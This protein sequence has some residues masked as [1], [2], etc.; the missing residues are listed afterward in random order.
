MDTKFLLT[1]P[2]EMHDC[3][4][5]QLDVILISGDSYIDSPYIGVAVI[6]RV[7]EKAGFR[8]GI[9]TQPDF[10]S[11]KDI[12]RLGEPRLFWGVTGGSVDSMVANTTASKKKRRTDDYTPG[13]VNDRRPDRA[14]MVYTNLIRRFYKNTRPIVLGGIE[15]SLRRVAHY[16]FWD[17]AIRRSILFD[18]KADYLLYGMAEGSVLALAQAL[19]LGEKATDLRGLCY[20]TREPPPGYLEL[21]SFEEVSADKSAFARMFHTFYQNN[22]PI[23]AHGLTQKHGDR[24]LVQ[25]PPAANPSQTE[26]DDIYALP[27]QRA[28]H[29]YYEK[30]GKVK[31][32]ETIRFSINMQRG[33]YGECNFCSIAVHEGRTVRWRSAASI[34]AEAEALTQLSGFKGYILDVGGPT[35]NMYGFECPLKL[36]EG[37]CV[38]KR[39]IYP[40]VCKALK[41]DHQKQT[42]LLRQLRQIP[43]VKKVFVGSGIR[44]DLVLA[45]KAHG[46]EYI[47]EITA[48][49]VSGQL[50]LA[51]EHS[52]PHVLEK[53]GKPLTNDL[54]EFKRRFD[55]HSRQA[56]KKQFITYYLIAAHPGCTE[57]DMRRLKQFASRELHISP[58]Q[59]QLFT[60]L[61]STYS[62]LMYYTG[63]DPFF[64]KPVF[65]EK[66]PAR[67]E[68]QKQIIVE[69]PKQV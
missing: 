38:H 11:G 25:N 36:K 18:A 39:C 13:G 49:H 65:V 66:D 34:L 59:V 56:G 22:D 44:Y 41:P 54:L 50:K 43:G 23:T 1:T 8:V 26:L 30:Q 33:C 4:W 40:V 46:D 14:V 21:P 32:L 55:D 17:D 3:G 9:I 52:E 35:A 62:A 5:D 10:K 51:P 53:M 7:L 67:R 24:F 12:S 61:P 47:R 64:P 29:P 27:Y 69:K 19:K 6:G 48:H 45:D 28:Q 60:P 2:E 58:E 63:L 15:A 42:D 57:V 16:D 37:A 20:I 31:A 68:R